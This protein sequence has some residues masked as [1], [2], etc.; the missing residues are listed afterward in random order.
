MTD[1]VIIWLMWSNWPRLIHNKVVFMSESIYL[2]DVIIWLMLA[3][4]LGHKW[5]T[6]SIYPLFVIIW[7]M[8]AVFLGHKVCT[9]SCFRC[10]MVV[11]GLEWRAS[12]TNLHFRKVEKWQNVN[13]SFPSFFLFATFNRSISK[14]FY[15]PKFPLWGEATAVKILGPSITEIF[16]ILQF[17]LFEGNRG[18]G[19]G[20]GH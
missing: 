7:L 20:G 5:I 14:S 16:I 11:I 6:L 15:M 4:F 9:L 12:S 1:N 13:F 18:R 3:V 2:L 8:L 19:G 17:K 10:S